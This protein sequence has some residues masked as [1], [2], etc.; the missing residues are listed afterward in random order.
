VWVPR[1]KQVSD[2]QIVRAARRVFLTH[3]TQAPVAMVAAELGVSPATLFVRMGTKSKLISAALWPPD[4]PVLATLEAGYRDAGSFEAQL[5]EVVLELASYAEAEIPATFTLYSA[6]LRAKP[7]DDF[8]EAT[9]TR[10]RRGLARWLAGAVRAGR[11]ECDPGVTAMIIVGTLEARV[12][13]AFIGK[14]PSSGRETREFV[15]GLVATVLGR[16]RSVEG[17]KEC[18]DP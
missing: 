18:S 12:L 10:L 5:L 3:G 16:S 14:R 1:K 7:S 6:G 11:I 15:R 2:A 4:P 13:H 9:P 17:G 8:S